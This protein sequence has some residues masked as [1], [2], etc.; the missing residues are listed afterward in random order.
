[1]SRLDDLWR[2]FTTPEVLTFLAVGGAGY[3]VDVAAFNALRSSAAVGAADPSYARILAVGLAMVVTYTGNR[4][5]TWAGQPGNDRRREIGL[6]VLFNLIGLG[7]SV[8]TLVISHDLLGLTSRL[9]D[10]VSANV[11]GLALGTLF[12]YWSYRTF[13]F[14]PRGPSV[15]ATSGDMTTVESGGLRT[16]PR[17]ATGPRSEST[18]SRARTSAGSETGCR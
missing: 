16:V 14:S 13:V 4:M 3:V 5:F 11:I 2:R 9:A 15:T 12:R 6:F 18:T 8:L 7:I 1:M 10:N 17:Q